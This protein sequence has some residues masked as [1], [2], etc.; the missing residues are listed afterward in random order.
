PIPVLINGGASSVGM[1]SVQ[2]AKRAGLFVVATASKRNHDRV[3]ALGADAVVDYT[4]KDWPEQVRKLTGDKLEHA[5]DCISEKETLHS[6]A[7]AISSKGGHVVCI[8]PRKQDELDAGSNVKVES[9]IVYT[10]FGRDLSKTAYK[11]FDN[12]EPE[13]LA[14]DKASWEKYLTQ[15]PEDLKSGKVVP[16]AIRER[17]GLDDLH[18]GFEDQRTGKV[19][20]EKLVYTV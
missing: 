20:A 4:E 10:V 19:S 12:T 1:Y 3:K 9:T 2:I 16:N 8:L 13:K 15:L 11:A 5:F 6:V 7:A 18:A 14:A 17:G